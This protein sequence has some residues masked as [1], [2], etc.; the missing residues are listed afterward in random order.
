MQS[1]EADKGEFVFILVLKA[2]LYPFVPLWSKGFFIK[3]NDISGG[4]TYE[5]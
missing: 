4:E 5:Q 2:F 3:K 1:R